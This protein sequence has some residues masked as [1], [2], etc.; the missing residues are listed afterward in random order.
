MAGQKATRAAKSKKSYPDLFECGYLYCADC[1]DG[2][3]FDEICIDLCDFVKEDSS[4]DCRDGYKKLFDTF[5]MLIEVLRKKFRRVVLRDFDVSV[6]KLA[7]GGFAYDSERKGMLDKA[8]GDFLSKNS[9]LQN[10]G[11]DSFALTLTIGFGKDAV[12]C[13]IAETVLSLFDVY[14]FKDSSLK[15]I[16]KVDKNHN[17][18]ENCLGYYLFRKALDISLKSE[19]TSYMLC[20]AFDL[21]DVKSVIPEQTSFKSGDVGGSMCVKKISGNVST[22]I[23]NLPRLALESAEEAKTAGSEEIL[24]IF[25][26]KWKVIARECRRVLAD[27]IRKVAGSGDPLTDTPVDGVFHIS[28]AV[29]TIT[30][31]L[32]FVGLSQAM[33]ILEGCAY[34]EDIRTM[35]DAVCVVQY[36]AEYCEFASGE[37]R[38]RYVL[39]S[40]D[41]S[42][43]C[44]VFY[45][46]DKKIRLNLPRDIHS[47]TPSFHIPCECKIAPLK[48]VQGEGVFGRYCFNEE[49]CVDFDSGSDISHIRQLLLQAIDSGVNILTLRKV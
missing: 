8:I 40:R 20:D 36:M 4:E 38:V 49:V 12:A 45:A 10:S 3:R 33:Y 2:S 29:G 32:G 27:R 7:G 19:R 21:G 16:F 25:K 6:T 24:R 14:S 39:S 28:D 15:V 41:S 17:L 5:D 30:L 35:L 9:R 37:D 34:H 47:Y 1:G 42:K 48:K 43:A 22:V 31:S 46:I 18:F 11:A 44:D 13:R 23:V 26:S